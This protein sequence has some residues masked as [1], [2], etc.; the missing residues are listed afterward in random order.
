MQVAADDAGAF[1]QHA[2]GYGEAYAGGGASHDGGLAGEPV[3]LGCHGDAL[4]FG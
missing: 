2:A 1:R 3:L 4:P